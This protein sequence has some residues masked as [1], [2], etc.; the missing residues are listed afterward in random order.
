MEYKTKKRHLQ[1]KIIE[2]D[3]F[4]ISFGNM[5]VL[6]NIPL[7]MENTKFRNQ[8]RKLTLDFLY[9]GYNKNL[10]KRIKDIKKRND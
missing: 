5:E 1:G 8:L 6:K 3:E 4:N 7:M 9:E 2:H 10:D